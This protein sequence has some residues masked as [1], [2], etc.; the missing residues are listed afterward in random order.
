MKGI[1][2][3]LIVILVLLVLIAIFILFIKTSLS[4]F[5]REYFGTSSLKEAIEKSEIESQ[6]TPKSVASMESVSLASIRKDFP[7]LNIN[8]IKTMAENSILDY[9]KA[10]QKKDLKVVENYNNT[11]KSMVEVVINNM[12]DKEAVYSNIKFHKTVINRYEKSDDIATIRLESSLEYYYK[13]NNKINKKVQDRFKV[14]MIYVIDAS[15]VDKDKKLLGLN[16]PN[17]GA[18]ITS[19]GIKKCKYCDTVIKDI[20]NRTWVVNNIKSF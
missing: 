19:L 12:K 16:C 20:I 5:L 18:P 1:I 6:E 11:I 4:R 13:E 2:G 15:K 7:D 14:E 8:E 3:I 10:I 9:F 17:C